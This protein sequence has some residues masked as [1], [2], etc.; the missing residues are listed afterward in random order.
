MVDVYLPAPSNSV[1]KKFFCVAWNWKLTVE[2]GSQALYIKTGDKS[3]C[4]CMIT[5]LEK[6][7]CLLELQVEN[8]RAYDL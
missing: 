2:R 4:W 6:E 1:V 5:K 7:N 3:C 8:S